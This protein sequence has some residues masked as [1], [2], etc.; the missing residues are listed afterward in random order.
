MNGLA[1]NFRSDSIRGRL[2]VAG[3]LALLVSMAGAFFDRQQFF[4]AYL[5]AYL[6]T[7]GFPLGSLAILMLHHLVG[8]R[9]GF[10]TQRVLEAAVG[11]LPLAA[12]LFLPLLFGMSDLYLWARPEAVSAD[13]ILQQKAAYLNLPFFWTRA[14]IYFSSWII[15]GHLLRKWS[16]EQDRTAEV[17]LTERLQTLSGPGLVLFGFTVTFS[18]IDWVMSLEPHWYSTI[19]GL[20]FV[21]NDSLAAL[22]M[23]ICAASLLAQREPLSQ[24]AGS[25]R[26]HDL[27]N[28]LLALVMLWAYLG[29]SQF[30]LIW[31]ENLREEI[32]WILHRSTGGW[33]IVALLLVIGKFVLPFALLLGRSTKRNARYLACVGFLILAMHWIDLYWLVAP[34]F[35]PDGFNIHWLDFAMLIGIGAIWLTV[36]LWRLEGRALLPLHDPRFAEEIARVQKV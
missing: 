8:G 4:R 30:M 21:V 27:G 15:L 16:A 14:A 6:F 9:W 35:H 29:F 12:L 5:T 18:A 17:S 3:L 26:F 33:E 10:V 22:A 11:T 2:L 31:V 7:I 19:Y 20:I 24:A 13:P 25:D 32:P 23:A 34:A 36:F 1:M 28:L